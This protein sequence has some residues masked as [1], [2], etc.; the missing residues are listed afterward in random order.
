MTLT[1]AGGNAQWKVCHYHMRARDAQEKS[2]SL[3]VLFFFYDLIYKRFPQVSFP[4]RAR[5]FENT[6]PFLTTK[7]LAMFFQTSSLLEKSGIHRDQIHQAKA[8]NSVRGSDN[9]DKQPSPD[10]T[11]H[12]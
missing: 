1:C 8:E 9:S 12:S 11:C 3:T 10:A 5:P 7:Y 6:H 2:I 4:F